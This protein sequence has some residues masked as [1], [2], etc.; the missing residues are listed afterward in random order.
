MLQT[1]RTI[2]KGGYLQFENLTYRGEN[3]AGYAGERVV[4]RFEPRDITTILVYR[5][6]SERELFLAK[7]HAADLETEQ[8]SLD[9]AKASSR[10]IREQGKTV[11]NRSILE[12]VHERDTFVAQKKS[13]K[14]RQKTEQAEVHSK[15]MPPKSTL[16]EEVEETV[17]VPVET[18][19]ERP[20]VLDYDQ[21]REDYGW[22]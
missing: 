10:K 22:D 13:R 16:T 9:E 4:L 20:R 6:E 15:R 1:N 11:S 5:K 12:E 2:Y 3:L 17:P 14:S 8:L 18:R 7:A 19:T 21:L